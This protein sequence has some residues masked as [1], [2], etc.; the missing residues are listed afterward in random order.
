MHIRDLT[1]ADE[2]A[3]ALIFARAWAHAFPQHPRDIDRETFLHETDGEVVIV[4]E[5]DG[6]ALGFAAVYRPDD[7]LHHLYV[8][9]TVHRLGV[10]RALIEAARE[11]TGGGLRLRCQA[12]NVNALGFYAHLGFREYERGRDEY[13]EWIGLRI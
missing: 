10:G 12:T 11:R 3:C 9:P 4:A 2:D 6:V 7:F 1:E 13:G 5:Q 8:D